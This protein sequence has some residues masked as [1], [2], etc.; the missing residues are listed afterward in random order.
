MKQPMRMKASRIRREDAASEPF[1]F[2][3]SD[4]RHAAVQHDHRNR[5]PVYY[6]TCIYVAELIEKPPVLPDHWPG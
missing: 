2:I 3:R 6:S 4:L 1:P 5:L